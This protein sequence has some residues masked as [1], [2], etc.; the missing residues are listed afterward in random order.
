M[1]WHQKALWWFAIIYA[2]IMTLAIGTLLAL[3]VYYRL[4]YAQVCGVAIYV[5][6]SEIDDG[7]VASA[8]GCVVELIK[9]Y[10]KLVLAL[11]LGFVLSQLVNLV[12]LRGAKVEV[13][14]PGGTGA[15]IGGDDVIR[16]GDDVKVEKES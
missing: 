15:K 8:F 11:V 7:K 9:V 16:S 13:S 14:G 4:A 5:A 10:D 12:V 6:G 2:S 3:I 1:T